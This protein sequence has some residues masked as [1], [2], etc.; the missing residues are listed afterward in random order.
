MN[1]TRILED[2]RT[3]D[4]IQESTTINYAAAA[5]GVDIYK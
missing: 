3:H 1:I 2:G 5:A 4:Y